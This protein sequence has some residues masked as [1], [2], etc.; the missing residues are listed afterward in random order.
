MSHVDAGSLFDRIRRRV[1]IG[2]AG[3][4]GSTLPV[5][6]EA[7]R[8]VRMLD[9]IDRQ[10]DDMPLI[11]RPEAGRFAL[12]P[13]H[14]ELIGL[15]PEA[16]RRS[17][18]DLALRLETTCAACRCWRQCARDLL[19]HDAA[20]LATYCPNTSLLADLALLPPSQQ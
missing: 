11:T 7:E 4:G 16:I 3:C 5:S 8:L 9:E 17:R 10:L 13:A 14:L 20:A 18:P 1:R 6:P 15:A 12:M 19:R 2:L